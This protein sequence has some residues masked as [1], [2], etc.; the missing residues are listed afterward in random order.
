MDGPVVTGVEMIRIIDEHG[1]MQW[2]IDGH[3]RFLSLPG[4]VSELRL[5]VSLIR[6]SASLHSAPCHYKVASPLFRLHGGWAVILEPDVSRNSELPGLKRRDASC[7]A[8]YVH[9]I[10]RTHN[11]KTYKPGDGFRFLLS[12]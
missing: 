2:C 12:S 9:T 11:S 5:G 4:D 3:T 8:F 7:K 10:C 1:G 6:I